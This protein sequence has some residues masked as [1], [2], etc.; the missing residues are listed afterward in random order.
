MGFDI[1]S[2]VTSFGCSNFAGKTF[3][4]TT[5]K[6]MC[7]RT[8]EPTGIIGVPSHGKI[9]IVKSL[10]IYTHNNCYSCDAI[11]YI[12]EGRVDSSLPWTLIGSGD[13]PWKDQAMGRNSRGQT[14]DSTFGNGDPKLQFTE[15]D[16]SS[17]VLS[18]S[19][20]KLTF[21]QQGILPQLGSKLVKLN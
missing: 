6:Y 13:L 19:E 21:P 16:F 12:L 20:Y 1:G 5:E 10:R 4:R 3:D 11:D 7:S 17:N 9:S 14:V 8:G 15:I 18:F 2:T